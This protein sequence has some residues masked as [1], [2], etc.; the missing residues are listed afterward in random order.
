MAELSAQEQKATK[1][2]KDKIKVVA[3]EAEV[4]KL[5]KQQ[6]LAKKLVVEEF[7]SSNDFQ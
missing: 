5:K 4:T 6:A 7:K 1:E 3:L 2:L